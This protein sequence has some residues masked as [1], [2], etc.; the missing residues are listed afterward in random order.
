MKGASVNARFCF[1]LLLEA[2]GSQIILWRGLPLYQR[3]HSE[4]TQGASPAELLIAIA[5]VVLMQTAHWLAVPLL[6]KMTLPRKPVTGYALV[7]IGE[8][9]LIFAT[10]FTAFIFFDLYGELSYSPWKV[11]ILLAILYASNCYKHILGLIGDKLIG[12]EPGTAK[13]AE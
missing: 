12:G 1:L 5:A 6:P 7:A 13:D 3:L 4:P 8:C 10:A 2:I 11:L 9:S